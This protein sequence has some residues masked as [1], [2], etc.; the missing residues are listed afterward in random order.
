VK[1]IA[2]MPQSSPRFLVPM[3]LK[4]WFAERGITRV[5]ELDWWEHAQHET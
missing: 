5:D 4:A 1:R 2:A 3:G